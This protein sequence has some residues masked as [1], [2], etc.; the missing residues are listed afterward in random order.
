TL[1]L[2]SFMRFNLTLVSKSLVE[3]EK[4]C[5]HVEAYT[6]IIQAR[7]AGRLQIDFKKPEKLSNIYI[8]PSTIQPL[9][10]NCIQHG[11]RDKSTGGK[12]ERSEEHTSELQSR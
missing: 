7:F 5:E 9:V 12:V 3:L 10:E 4:E 6:S 1:K 11:L 8:P 2:A